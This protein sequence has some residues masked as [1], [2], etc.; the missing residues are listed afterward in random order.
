MSILIHRECT[1]IYSPIQHIIMVTHNNK[2]TK[3]N[4]YIYFKHQFSRVTD[5]VVLYWVL[6]P[7]Y[8][9]HY[10]RKSPVSNY[11]TSVLGSKKCI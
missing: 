9:H 7:N 6:G 2:Q 8:I 3:I 5:Y 4:K 11:L 10:I 1:V